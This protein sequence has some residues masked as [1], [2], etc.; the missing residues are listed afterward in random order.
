M[1]KLVIGLVVTV[2]AVVI[3]MIIYTK[4]VAKLI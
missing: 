4:F 3:A 2:V 1:S